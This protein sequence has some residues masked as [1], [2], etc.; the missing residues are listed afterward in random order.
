MTEFGYAMT[1][2]RRSL[3]EQ[4]RR[5]WKAGSAQIYIDQLPPLRG[6]RPG[7]LALISHAKK[8]DAVFV[9]SIRVLGR[10]LKEVIFSAAELTR[11]GVLIKSLD[12]SIDFSPSTAKAAAAIFGV[13]EICEIEFEYERDLAALP[14]RGRRAGTPRALSSQQIHQVRTE[15]AAGKYIAD[16]IQRFEVSRATIYRAV[17]MSDKE[18]KSIEA[19][20]MA[21]ASA[22][23]SRRTSGT[24]PQKS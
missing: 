1:F 6:E 17:K 4:R 18:L 5:L 21:V 22:Q 15:K 12:K 8:G 9:V 2:G 3:D 24:G 16:L 23:S 7:F 20:E 10:S 11:K 19:D 13:L 14:R